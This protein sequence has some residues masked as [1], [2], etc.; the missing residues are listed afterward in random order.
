MQTIPDTDDDF[1][2]NTWLSFITGGAPLPDMTI[3]LA[4]CTRSLVARV[5]AQDPIRAPWKTHPPDIDIVNYYIE[6]VQEPTQTAGTLCPTA[7]T[8]VPQN[9]ETTSHSPTLPQPTDETAL[10]SPPIVTHTSELDTEMQL[11]QAHEAEMA[12]RHSQRI[13]EFID[14]QQRQD[15]ESRARRRQPH[16]ESGRK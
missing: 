15:T 11:L 1:D 10:L 13:R 9:S 5:R 6:R 16:W 2:P 4:H 8:I 12:A 14:Q 7:Y 3:P